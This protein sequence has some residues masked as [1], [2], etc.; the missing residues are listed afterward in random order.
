M[1]F[2]TLVSFIEIVQQFIHPM[3]VGVTQYHQAHK[4][5]EEVVHNMALV[6]EQGIIYKIIEPT[7]K[8]IFQLYVQE[9]STIHICSHWETCM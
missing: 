2:H 7:T 8:I 6:E 4:W 3:L 9:G 1:L 5:I